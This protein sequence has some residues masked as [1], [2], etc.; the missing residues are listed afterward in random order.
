MR[1]LLPFVL[2]SSIATSAMAAPFDWNAVRVSLAAVPFEDCGKPAPSYVDVTF[3]PDGQVASTK[4]E[5]GAFAEKTVTCIEARFAKAQI[6]PY[7]GAAQ[8]VRFMLLPAPPL[9]PPIVAASAPATLPYD[10]ARAV[11]SG[12]HVEERKRTGLLVAGAIGFGAGAL[13]LVVVAAG[14]TKVDGVPSDMGNIYIAFGGMALLAG[15]GLFV[16][17]LS[18]RKV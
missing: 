17:G 16:A 7:E 9:P 14:K 4:A 1:A 6:A 13:L 15:G 10:E 12:Y 5:S 3:A 18:P 2:A 11:P 8:S